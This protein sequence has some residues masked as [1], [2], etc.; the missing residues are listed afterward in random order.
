MSEKRN[1]R[2]EQSRSSMRDDEVRPEAAWKPPS[3]LDAPEARPG[4]VQR[5]VATSIQGKDTPDN[6]YKR[7]REGWEPRSAET[8]KS[9]LFPTINHGQW[10]GSIGIEGMLLCEMPKE[11]HA[12][13][14]AYYLNKSDEQ[15][16][17]VVGELDAL[18]R[19]SGLPIHQDRQSETSRGRTLS[20][21][22]D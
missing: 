2:A 12:S 17:S 5:W 16:E 9:K 10:T 11:R 4:Y 20:A 21:M 15:N 3:L 7:M 1:V 18:G 22:S 19:Q 13:M 8:V 6:V 14:K